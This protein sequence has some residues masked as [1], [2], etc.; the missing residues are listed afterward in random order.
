MRQHSC[1]AYIKEYLPFQGRLL[2][3]KSHLR[4]F[5]HSKKFCNCTKQFS[6]S[7]SELLKVF[8]CVFCSIYFEMAYTDK[9]QRES[10]LLELSV[11]SCLRS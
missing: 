10:L 8:A 5:Y 1:S 6:K 9:I 2:F 3:T 11:A 7:K 4:A